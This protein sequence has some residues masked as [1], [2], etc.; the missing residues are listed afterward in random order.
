MPDRLFSPGAVLARLPHLSPLTTAIGGLAVWL[1]IVRALRWRRYNA[2]HR[3]YG[4]KWNN[5]LGVLDPQEA[6]E[7]MHTSTFYDM[8]TLLYYALSFSLFKTYA[9][10]SISKLLVATKELSTKGNVSRR[11][12]DTELLISTWYICPISGFSDPAFHLTN[13]GPNAKPADDP[14]ANI[15]LA[16]ANWLHSK[17]KISN[18]DFLY[19]LCLFVTGSIYWSDLYGWRSLSALEKHAFYVFWAEVGRRMNIKDIPDSLEAMLAYSKQYE[20]TYMVPMESNRD[21]STYSLDELLGPVPEAFGLKSLATKAVLSVLDNITREAMMYEKQPWIIRAAVDTVMAFVAFVQR[22]LLLP[23]YSGHSLVEYG[24][25]RNVKPGEYCARPWYKP[26]SSSTAG[27][28]FDMLLVKIG[29]YLEM[30]STQLKS[31]GYRLEE[32]GPEK[33]ENDGHE[34]VM[35]NA[36]KLQG[37]PVTGPWSSEGRK[38]A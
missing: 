19:T 5:G 11:L 21:V 7:I 28:Y 24:P 8:P 12:S 31:G 4:P 26:Q 2:I 34:E 17:Y 1:L 20:D 18:S 14:R 3:K 13:K 25:P 33:F 22:F 10:P 23:R 38:S 6:Q 30:P 29:Y 36:A 32:M 37:C 16:R 27:Y 9:I 35:R 15:A